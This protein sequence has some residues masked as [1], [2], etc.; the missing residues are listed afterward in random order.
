MAEKCK[1]HKTFH[2]LGDMECLK[3]KKQCEKH[4][5]FHTASYLYP[6]WKSVILNYTEVV[7]DNF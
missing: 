6:L 5:T 2:N 3:E 4:K 7:T 1:F